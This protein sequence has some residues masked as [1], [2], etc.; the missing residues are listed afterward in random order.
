MFTDKQAG[1]RFDETYL[2][3]ARSLPEAAGWRMRGEVGVVRIGRGLLGEDVQNRLHRLVG[4]DELSLSYLDDT[5]LRAT[6]R[7]EARRPLELGGSLRAA[8]L[9]DLFEAFGFKRHGILGAGFRWRATARFRVFWHAAFRYSSTE[10][11]ALE[12]WVDGWAPAGEVGIGYRELLAVSLSHNAYGTED[13][14]L[15]LRF[16]WR[17][18]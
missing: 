9:I 2:A 7:V 11:E 13:R 17:F 18:R 12:P 3:A 14:H 5:K 6:L 4:A 1:A 10:L 8:P 15:Q 16:R